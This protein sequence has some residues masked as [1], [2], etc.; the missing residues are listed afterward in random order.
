MIH[1]TSGKFQGSAKSNF[2]SIWFQ[3]D[4]LYMLNATLMLHMYWQVE[5]LYSLDLESLDSLRSVYYLSQS[6]TCNDIGYD[7]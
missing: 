5:E 7:N 3:L 6:W 4:F 1:N 2:F